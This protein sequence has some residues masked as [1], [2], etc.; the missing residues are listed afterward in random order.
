MK[1]RIQIL[2]MP[3]RRGCGARVST[4]S[5]PIHYKQEVYDRLHGICAKCTTPEE[6]KELD[7]PASLNMSALRGA[8]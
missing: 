8:A 5:R 1:P 6:F 3:C 2:S 4:V 7:S